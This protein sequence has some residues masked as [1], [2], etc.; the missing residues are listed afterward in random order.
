[1]GEAN[2]DEMAGALPQ[3]DD[4]LLL[5]M[6]V[7]VGPEY[8]RR[9]YTAEALMEEGKRFYERAKEERAQQK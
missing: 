3:V 9:R 1:M 4:K 2:I 7:H 5:D 8:L 6:H